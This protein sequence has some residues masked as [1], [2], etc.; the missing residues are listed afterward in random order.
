V[1]EAGRLIKVEDTVLHDAWKAGGGGSTLLGQVVTKGEAEGK[2]KYVA[3]A[4]AWLS[5]AAAALSSNAG[6]VEEL[7]TLQRL[8]VKILSRRDDLVVRGYGRISP[9]G[10][11]AVAK[12][13]R[14]AVAAAKPPLDDITKRVLV[15]LAIL[16]VIVVLK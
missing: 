9:T 7:T 8:Y 11:D 13:A 14:A 16:A 4:N 2:H 15:A 12:A 6:S 3:L 1:S 10:E 5:E